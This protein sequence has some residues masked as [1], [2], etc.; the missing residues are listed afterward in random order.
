[1]RRRSESSDK[2]QDAVVVPHDPINEQVLIAAVC[3]DAKAWDAL[4]PLIPEA[5]FYGKGHEPIWAA[6]RAMQRRGL[7]Y[8][9][10]TLQQMSAGQADPKYVEQLVAARP[11]APPNLGHHVSMLRWD[12]NLIET[13]RGPLSEL[14]LAVRDR[15]TPQE[16]VRALAHHVADAFQGFGSDGHVRRARDVAK[17]HRQV[18]H[19]RRSGQ[20]CY[21]Y[22]IPDLDVYPE[23]TPHRARNGS[24]M[25][26]RPRMVP[27]AAPKKMTMI[28]G[29]SGSYKSVLAKF[30]GL[31]QVELGRKVL[32]GAWEEDEEIALEDMAA[33]ALGLSKYDVATGS[34]SAAD[35]DDLAD[36]MERLDPWLSFFTLPHEWT[37][38]LQKKANDK[39]IDT[40]F[41]VVADSKCDVF[42]GDLLNRALEENDPK[43]EDRAARRFQAMNK[44]LGIHLIAVHQQR[45]KDVETRTD[46]RPTR[47]GMK[48]S[49]TWVEVADQ[50]L[51]VHAESIWKD[52]PDDKIEIIV[53]KQRRAP[54]PMAV[55]FEFDPAFPAFEVGRDVPYRRPGE[56]SSMDEFLG[57]RG[58]RGR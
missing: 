55:E 22:G 49:A 18:L 52:V 44:R 54:W 20:A 35:A 28:T 5:F 53:M 1:M 43:D 57:K 3:V 19:D 13:C 47:E 50:I 2:A 34:Y 12:R 29:V 31:R 39:A 42:I 26:G 10:A 25:A 41:Q 27:G 36:E 30:I 8:D 4:L 16:K 37:H 6:L 48:G 15:K 32:F 51:G 9:P 17:D 38:S 23:G 21:P 33:M 46:N 40:I 24:S 58:R 45:L 56:D 7:Y 11:A 14:L